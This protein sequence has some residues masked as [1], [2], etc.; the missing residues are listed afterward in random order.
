MRE[1]LRENNLENSSLKELMAR[2]V[3]T[4]LN[5]VDFN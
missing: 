5:G 2:I 4:M 1:N 3:H